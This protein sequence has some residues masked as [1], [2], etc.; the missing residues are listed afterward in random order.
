MFSPTHGEAMNQVDSQSLNVI[1]LGR[2]A[3]DRALKRQEEL[4]AKRKNGEAPDTLLLVEHEP[5]YTL[6]RSAKETNVLLSGDEL[7]RKGIEVVKTGRGGD[8]TFHGPGQLVGYPI[9]D[10]SRWGKGA[11]WY[12]G[13]LEEVI[14][15]TLADYGIKGGRDEK[16]RGVWIGDKKIAAIGVRIT[17]HVT[18]HG[19]SLNVCVNLDYYKGIVP[20]GIADK[21]V[22]S[23]DRLVP[24]IRM[25]DVKKKIVER[26][27]E[28]FGYD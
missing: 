17:R 2:M 8:V 15:R 9:L 14:I 4:V 18:M 16:H 27:K 25:E 10:L 1:D 26:F 22:T 23:L 5:V 11:V 13:S 24:G 7:K 3:Y 21:G 6:G 28:V 20:C 19:F 12:V